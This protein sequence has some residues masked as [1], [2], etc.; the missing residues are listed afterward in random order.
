MK[1]NLDK[2]FTN[3]EVAQT[4]CDIIQKKIDIDYFDDFV[5]EPSAG[6]GSFIGPMKR[7]CQNNLFIDIQPEHS[8]IQKYNYLKIKPLFF[9]NLKKTNRLHVIGNPP[10][11]F[12]GSNAIKFIKHSCEFCDTFSFI[13]PLSFAKS[14]MQKTVPSQFHLVHSYHIPNHSFY[15][16]EKVFDIPCVFQIWEKKEYHRKIDKKVRPIGYRFVKNQDDADVAVRRVGSYAG[17]ILDIQ[18]RN[19]NSHY[20]VKLDNPKQL[21]KLKDI[22]IPSNKFVTGPRSISKKDIIKNLNKMINKTFGKK[23]KIL[24]KR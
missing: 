2:F 10:F 21:I 11:G 9:Q 14:S 5:I 13:L 17:K 23:S 16:N 7:L 3:T 22:N 6:D 15:Y 18:N 19:S 8:E 24:N 12:R 4:C 1:K 20:F